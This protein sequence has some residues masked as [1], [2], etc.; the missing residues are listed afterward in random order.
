MPWLGKKAGILTTSGSSDSWWFGTIISDNLQYQP[1]PWLYT[2]L[3]NPGLIWYWLNEDDC[4]PD[5]KKG[6]KGYAKGNG[7]GKGYIE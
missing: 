1:A 3:K 5:R 6:M 4:S 7:D 2:Q